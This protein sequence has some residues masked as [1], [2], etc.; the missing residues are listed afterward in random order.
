MKLIQAFFGGIGRLSV[1]KDNIV[2]W[3]VRSVE[4]IKVI[5]DHIECFPLLS[6][7]KI[8]FFLFKE[9]LNIINNKDHLKEE[10]LIKLVSL[11]ASMNKGLS[12]ILKDAFSDINLSVANFDKEIQ[13]FLDIKFKD[14]DPNWIAGFTEAEGCFFVI[15]QENTA[16]GSHLVKLGFQVS[17]HVW[18]TLL[19]KSLIKYFEC[20]RTEPAGKSGISFRITKLKNILEVLVPFFEKYPLLGN[21]A[22]DFKDWKEITQLMKNKAHLTREGLNKIKEIKSRM[23]YL[24]YSQEEK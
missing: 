5:I 23:N 21:K 10:G 3:R 7:K 4:E 22:K 6:K 13:K 16:K 8:D 24:R 1:T 12:N 19:I 14:F 18:D 11:K 9:A 20:G 15:V 2:L 17:Q